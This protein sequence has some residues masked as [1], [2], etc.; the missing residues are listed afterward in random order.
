MGR[1]WWLR[2]WERDR[3]YVEEE[4]RRQIK[5]LVETHLFTGTVPS[6]GDRWEVR[7]DNYEATTDIELH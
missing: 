6:S 4:V 5:E 7:I 2:E 3:E 1:G